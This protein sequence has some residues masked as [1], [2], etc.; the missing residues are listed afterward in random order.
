LATTFDDWDIYRLEAVMR[1][2]L[3]DEPAEADS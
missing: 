2:M 3:D 1:E